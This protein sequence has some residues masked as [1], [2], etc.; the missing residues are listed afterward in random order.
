M[1]RDISSVLVDVP[2]SAYHAD[3]GVVGHSALVQ[4]LRSPAHFWAYTNSEHTETPAF[5]F[6]RALH[7]AV[8]EPQQFA[9]FYAKAPKFDL[10]TKLG[11][12]EKAEWL[13]KH[14]TKNPLDEEALTAI[15]RIR[16]N[17]RSH[18]RACHILKCG[19]S[20][21]SFFWTD[22]DTG[23]KLRVRFDHVHTDK[24]GA[25]RALLDLKS[26][27]CASKE[28]FSRDMA[29]YGYDVQ[30]ALYTDACWIAFGVE[31][32]FYFLA[33]ES[34]EPFGVA[35]Y[36]AGEA[37]IEAGRRKYRAA[38]QL[39]QWCRDKNRW[40]SYQPNGEEEVIDIPAWELRRSMESET[41]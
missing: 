5:R 36:R 25:P 30:A 38:L 34:A 19:L 11:K 31:L 23:V 13:R 26:T 32:P 12:E 37:T 22:M 4:I 9:L 18:E 33:A 39:L 24:C 8:L 27:L 1:S 20:E 7:T 21:R 14:P 35:L 29:K 41:Y 3:K 16:M 28:S 15:A 10:R 6:G 2:A 40:P 17:V